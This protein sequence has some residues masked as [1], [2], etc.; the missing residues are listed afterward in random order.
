MPINPFTPNVA[1]WV[2]SYKASCTHM[3]TVG[4]K[5]LTAV[6]YYGYKRKTH[7]IASRVG[8]I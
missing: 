3:A 8:V 5:G 1:T 2:Y 6:F 7:N 4:V